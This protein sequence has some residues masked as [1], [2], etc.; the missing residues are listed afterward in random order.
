MFIASG[1]WAVNITVWFIIRINWV[2]DRSLNLDNC[3]ELCQVD[4]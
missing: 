2:V 3:N 1:L 4:P